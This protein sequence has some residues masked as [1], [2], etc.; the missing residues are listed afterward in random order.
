[1]PPVF[2]HPPFLCTFFILVWVAFFWGFFLMA[3]F[4]HFFKF[5]HFFSPTFFFPVRAQPEI[6]ANKVVFGAN[7]SK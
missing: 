1:M 4:L 2:N 6:L 5:W 3:T 7:P